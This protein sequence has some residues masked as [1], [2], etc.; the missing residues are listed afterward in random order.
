MTVLA[1]SVAVYAI[2]VLALPAFGPPFIHERRATMPLAVWAHLAGGS[3][4]LALGPWQF[5]SSVRTRAIAVHRW[6]G[7]SYVIAVLV[8][9]LG[10]LA[11]APMSQH[12]LV[13]RSG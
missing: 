9:G 1:L 3:M 12:G 6:T 13:T 5:L 10:G 7:R 2:A 11:L 4:A 8:G